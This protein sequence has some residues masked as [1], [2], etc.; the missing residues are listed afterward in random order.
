MIYTTQYDS[1]IGSILLAGDGESLTGLWFACQKYFGS[2]LPGGEKVAWSHEWSTE[3]LPEVCS[4]D[5][6]KVREYSPETSQL[7]IFQTTKRWLDLYFHGEIPD[8]TPALRLSGTPFRKAVWE[9]LLTIPYGRTM[10]YGEIADKIAEQKGL[11]RMSAQAVGS[12]VGHNPISIIVPCH[13]VLGSD[14]SLTGY[15]GGV[16]RKAALLALEQPK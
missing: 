6:P 11:P 13:R 9:I 7:P 10:T 16:E 8:F 14:G 5:L 2:T 4:G 3:G 1:P 12:A 15:A